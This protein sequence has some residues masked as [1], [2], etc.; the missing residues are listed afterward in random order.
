MDSVVKYTSIIIKENEN[1]KILRIVEIA[2]DEDWYVDNNIVTLWRF[3]KFVD[4]NNTQIWTSDGW[5]NIKKL[6][7]HK[8]E[9]DIFRIRTKHGI[10]YVTEDHRLSNRNREIMKPCDLEIGEELLHNFMNFNDSQ[11]TFVEIINKIYNI[12][13]GTLKE[14]EM[15]V[16]VFF[17]IW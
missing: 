7:R 6:I 1:I 10:V 11:F 16:K 9:K 14:K 2:D 5:R 3:R 8:I 4:G 17:R 13:P 12:E 15:F